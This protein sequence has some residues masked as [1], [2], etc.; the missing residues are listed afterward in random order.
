MKKCSNIYPIVFP[1]IS[2][3]KNIRI[4]LSQLKTF[5]ATYFTRYFKRVWKTNCIKLQWW[6]NIM[7]KLQSL[8]KL[9]LCRKIPVLCDKSNTF[10]LTR[11]WNRSSSDPWGHSKQSENTIFAPNSLEFH[12][13]FTRFW[14]SLLLEWK[15][16]LVIF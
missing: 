10:K 15:F 12:S 7:F 14:N 5:G 16:S 9:F 11:G 3:S 2:M 8:W 4:L 1:F 6:R 13:K